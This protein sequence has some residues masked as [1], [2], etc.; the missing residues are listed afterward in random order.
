MRKCLKAMLVHSLPSQAG[1]LTT[2]ATLLLKLVLK[3]SDQRTKV[4]WKRRKIACSK[5][6]KQ[7]GVTYSTLR[8]FS[9]L[10]AAHSYIF[11][12]EHLFVFRAD[13]RSEKSKQRIALLQALVVC[14]ELQDSNCLELFEKEL[15]S[16][17]LENLL[18]PAVKKRNKC[19][20]SA[21]V[22]LPRLPATLYD[23]LLGVCLALL[24]TSSP[25]RS[26]SL[27]KMT[28]E[29]GTAMVD[30]SSTWLDVFKRNCSYETSFCI[31]DE[32]AHRLLSFYFHHLRS[33]ALVRRNRNMDASLSAPVKNAMG[34]H[35]IRNEFAKVSLHRYP[36][37]VYCCSLMP[38]LLSK[39]LLE[40]ESADQQ[41]TSKR[42]RF[43][44]ELDDGTAL[45][46]V[47]AV[48]KWQDIKH[49]LV[50]RLRKTDKKIARKLTL[51]QLQSY[52]SCHEMESV[53]PY[54]FKTRRYIILQPTFTFLSKKFTLAL[55]ETKIVGLD[56]CKATRY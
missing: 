9:L 32:D 37:P 24:Q 53:K 17:V 35:V 1:I 20:E 54:F 12:I 21:F 28:L 45:A 48:D 47:Q 34:R 56:Y 29:Q 19:F 36:R 22:S 50:D 55:F 46:G 52:A 40:R 27:M 5:L 4:E 39:V 33:I 38:V 7:D 30:W 26:E 25:Q 11:F 42:S 16:E 49:Q 14:W 44:C 6:L 2:N 43:D 51:H 15:V 41:S 18:T 3:N 10:C 31:L 8:F 23:E 13:L